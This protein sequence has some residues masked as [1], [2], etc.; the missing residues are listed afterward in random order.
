M[1]NLFLFILMMFVS[2]AMFSQDERSEIIKKDIARKRA[3]A[4]FENVKYPGDNNF[5]VIYYKLYLDI[6]HINKHLRGET[7]INIRSVIDDLT[8]LK[9]DLRSVLTVDS[10]FVDDEKKT[11]THSDHVITIALDSSRMNGE[12]LSIKIFYQGKPGTSGLGSFEFGTHGA[13]NVP[14]IWSLSEPYGAPDWFPCK[15]DPADKAD[16]CDVWVKCDSI[17]KVGSNGLLTEIVDNGDNTKTYKWK[18]RYPIAHYL[19][20]IAIS[21]YVEYINYFKYSPADSMPIVHY[22]Y[23]EKFNSTRINALNETPIM[24]E[25]FSNLFGLYPFINEKYGHTEMNWSG[26]MEHQTMTTMGT[27]TFSSGIIVHE[28]A[29]QWFGNLVT[30]SDWRNIWINEGFATYC[31]GIYKEA[32]NGVFSYKSFISNEMY[33]AK[34]ARGSIW[35][36]NVEDEWE[37]FNGD[38]SYSK[39]AI[40][41]HMLRGIVGDSTFFQ[42]LKEYLEEYK[43]S[44]AST[45]D[46][47]SV[48]E[49]VYGDTLGYF[50]N[51][52][53]YGENYPKYSAVWSYHNENEDLY[54]IDLTVEQNV[55][56]N[57]SFF[58]MPMQIK[59]Q[60]SIS[61]TLLTILN[62]AQIQNFEIYTLGKPTNLL[63]DPDNWILKDM[64]YFADTPN[65]ETIIKS[66]K[67]YQNY[68]NPFNPSTTI[69]FEL[70]ERSFVK[71]LIY[72]A[73][74][75]LVK[76]LSE[77]DMPAG[78]HKLKFDAQNLSSGVYYYRLNAGDFAITKKMILV[79]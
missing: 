57:P 41:L 20:S 36:Q 25:I 54:K 5:D 3:K 53:I 63:F 24:L 40:V 47:Q 23:P 10:V 52:W 6:D 9:I 17:F 56:T 64:I 12:L 59:I 13:S 77:E 31:E 49:R 55:N 51:Q 4:K 8:S 18:H 37:I 69:E 72:D 21:N 76:I 14:V 79:K 62:N 67:L 78:K 15:D 35:V 33:F 1:K 74:G 61:D 27:N 50:F 60:S 73:L 11:F 28:L 68:P 46:F 70:R 42:I 30:C 43:F 44:N 66:Y 39:G 16:S 29:H 48:A 19:I 34:R 22:N 71:I 58:T 7:T 65:D 75:K 38:R 32:I 2:T 45:E 26:A